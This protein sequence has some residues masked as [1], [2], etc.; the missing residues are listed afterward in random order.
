VK[1]K[2]LKMNLFGLFVE[3]DPD[4]H[5]LAHISELAEAPI[6]DP[7]TVASVGDVLEFK[8]ISLDPTH[9]R[10]GLSRRALLLETTPTPA[11]EPAS[12]LPTP[13]LNTESTPP[14]TAQM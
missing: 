8:I 6:H 7:A 3:L 12:D 4:I 13:K 10:L 11:S 5:G 14:K 9:H 1:G 2:V